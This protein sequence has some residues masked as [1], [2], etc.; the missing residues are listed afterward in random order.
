LDCCGRNFGA[1]WG[2]FLDGAEEES[3]CEA[4]G[5]RHDVLGAGGEKGSVLSSH[6]QNWKIHNSE[7]QEQSDNAGR[8][9]AQH[10]TE[11]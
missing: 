9:R 7:L 10:R 1:L 2:R 6:V 3:F 4:A 8:K 11:E 5:E